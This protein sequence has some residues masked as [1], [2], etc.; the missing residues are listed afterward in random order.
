LQATGSSAGAAA[1]PRAGAL[2]SQL[3]FVGRAVLDCGDVVRAGW[4]ARQALWRGRGPV[5]NDA[6]RCNLSFS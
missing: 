1:G 4:L 3:Q 5:G 6:F 2:G